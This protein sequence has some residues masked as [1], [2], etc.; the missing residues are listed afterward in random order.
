MGQG[1]CVSF[2]MDISC[3]PEIHPVDHGMDFSR[4]L[5]VGRGV[6]T[7]PHELC[8]IHGKEGIEL[9]PVADAQ[10]GNIGV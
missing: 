8:S 9:A 6:H 7:P 1:F 2:L 10:A 5:I 4:P 3:F